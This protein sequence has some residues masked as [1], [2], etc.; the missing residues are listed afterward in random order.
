MK[1]KHILF[2][3]IGLSIILIFIYSFNSGS[4]SELSYP[5][6]IQQY[7]MEKN[8]F[9]RNSN[10]SPFKSDQKTRF[11]GLNYFPVN[12][13]LIIKADFEPERSFRTRI[14][15]MST[16]EQEE[17]NVY[18]Y[19]NFAFNNQIHRLLI[20]KSADSKEE[21]LFLPFFDKTNEITTYG[22]GRYLEPELISDNKI[23]LDFN[24]AYNPYCAYSPD[25][26]CPLPPLEN[27]LEIPVNA[28]EKNYEKAH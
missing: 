19:A 24:Y 26:M 5:D 8:E 1:T 20:F 28:G 16:G 12:E 22:G 2:S 4:E 18:G 25:Y 9:M 6:E 14:L 3:V 7:R 27:R 11:S 10:E 23:L 13:N 17:Y 21:A 15:P